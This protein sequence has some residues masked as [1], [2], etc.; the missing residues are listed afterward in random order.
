M[1]Q[2]LNFRMKL[3]TLREERT[4]QPRMIGNMI[5][6]MLCPRFHGYSKAYIC[7]ICLYCIEVEAICKLQLL[8]AYVC[9]RSIRK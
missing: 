4:M 7:Y 2:L 1:S 9:S 5:S 3:F 8:Y 6:S